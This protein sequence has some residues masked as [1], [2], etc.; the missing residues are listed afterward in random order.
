MN[1][2]TALLHQVHPAKV[3]ADV[4]ASVISNVL[5]WHHR[6]GGGL[7]VR[8]ALP[9]AGSAAVLA[10]ADMEQLRDTPQGRY[11]LR[12]MGPGAQVTRLG[13]DVVMAVGAWQRRSSVML[14][15]AVLIAAG[16]SFGALPP[17][18]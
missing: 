5:L 6:L 16:W 7:F 8:I 11:V 15:G 14:V 10:F 1:R 2:E 4:T 13:G 3:G 12:N 9:V 18:G 17:R